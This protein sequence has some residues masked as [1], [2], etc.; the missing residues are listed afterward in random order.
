MLCL[1]CESHCNTYSDYSD[2]PT[3]RTHR[4]IYRAL[5]SNSLGLLKLL[6]GKMRVNILMSQH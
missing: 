1:F 3:L 5:T 4:L 6:L 2:F